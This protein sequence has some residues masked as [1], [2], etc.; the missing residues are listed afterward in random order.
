MRFCVLT[1][2]PPPP[3]PFTHPQVMLDLKP[4]NVLLTHMGSAVLTDFGISRVI[5]HT[6]RPTQVVG[7]FNYM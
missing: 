7:T 5:T 2:H 3:P 1:A 4:D 6:L